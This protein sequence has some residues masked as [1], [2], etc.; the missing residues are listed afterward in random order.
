MLPYEPSR[1]GRRHTVIVS[2]VHLSQAHPE[3][4]ADPLWMR[5]RKRE[6]H[7]DTDFASLVDHLLAEHGNDAIELV[8]NGDVLDFDA[9]W[10]K[11]GTSSF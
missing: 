5:Y 8:F 10:V 4:A 9:P 6:F 11:D 1:G 7:P 3:D 2:D